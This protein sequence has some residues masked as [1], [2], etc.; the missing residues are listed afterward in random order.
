MAEEPI[1]FENLSEQKQEAL[2]PVTEFA[3]LLFGEGVLVNMNL[4]KKPDDS[5]PGKLVTVTMSDG[6][7]TAQITMAE[8]SGFYERVTG[9]SFHAGKVH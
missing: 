7:N 2:G 9:H 8:G 6:K 5:I 1:P 3:A 4:C